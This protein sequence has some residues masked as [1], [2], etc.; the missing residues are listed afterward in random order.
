MYW[1]E[2]N[3]GTWQHCLQSVAS[4]PPQYAYMLL[5]NYYF[6][7]QRFLLSSVVKSSDGR[8]PYQLSGK[9]QGFAQ[10]RGLQASA[11]FQQRFSPLIG[12]SIG[13]E[14][15]LF[16]WNSLIKP[17]HVGDVFKGMVAWDFSVFQKAKLG[18]VFSKSPTVETPKVNRRNSHRFQVGVGS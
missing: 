11:C 7:Y 8:S 13:A 3:F 4:I 1:P 10:V 18:Y 9:N 14:P 12:R 17:P 16:L 2:K 6:F 5:R 15:K